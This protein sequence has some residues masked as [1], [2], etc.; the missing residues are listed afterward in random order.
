MVIPGNEMAVKSINGSSE[1][2][3]NNDFQSET[4][5][6]SISGGMLVALR[7]SRPLAD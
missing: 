6:E 1:Q 5:I 3:T 7:S 4:L 2:E